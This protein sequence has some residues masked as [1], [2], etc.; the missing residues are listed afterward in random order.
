M[1]RYN[2][3]I[4]K[5]SGGFATNSN[6]WLTD[7]VAETQ[8]SENINEAV[9]VY[10]E[11]TVAK[12]VLNPSSEETSAGETKVAGLLDLN[13]D[14]YYD[15]N[16]STMQ[17]LVYGDYAS[18]AVTYDT[19]ALSD[20]SALTNVN[21]VEDTSR[22]TTFYAKHKKGVYVANISDS[23]KKVSVYETLA[24]ISP[25]VDASGY[26]SA[27]KPVTKT[28]SNSYGLAFL[29][30]TIYLEGWDHSVVDQAIN[31]HFNLGLR[32]EINKN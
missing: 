15:Y 5:Q 9:R 24:T 2:F 29:D 16:P 6:I 27:G 30:A 3:R 1:S 18:G 17:E 25:A 28:S 23:D 12:Y 26:F 19:T 7:A 22:R 20:D 13:N 21:G 4:I 8:G 31:E 14:G 32:F 11:S 10:F